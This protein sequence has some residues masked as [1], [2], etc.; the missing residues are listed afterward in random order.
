MVREAMI[1]NRNAHGYEPPEPW[2]LSAKLAFW[3][4]VAVAV[5]AIAWRTT[6]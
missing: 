3:S 2:P 6:G 4:V 1:T 5:V